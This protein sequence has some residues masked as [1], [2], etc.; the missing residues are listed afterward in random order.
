M[1][2]G[3]RWLIAFP[4]PSGYPHI[5]QPVPWRPLMSLLVLLSMLC[6][7]TADDLFQDIANALKRGRNE[8]ALAL[9]E[10]AIKA[11]PKNPQ[12]YL[13]RGLVHAALQKHTEAVADFDKA[14]ELDPKMA[15]AYDQRGSER[16]KQGKIADALADFDRFLELRPKEYSG[17]WRRGIALYYLGKYEEGRKQFGA[18]EKVDTNDVENAVWHFLCNARLVGVEKARGEMLKIGN[19]K[20]VPLMQGYALFKGEIKPADVLTA[21]NA[22]KPSAAELKARLFY[23]HLYLGLYYEALGDGK[24]AL[25]HMTRAAEDYL[26]PGYMGDVARVHA[27]LRKKEAK[28]K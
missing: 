26:L 11:D 3:V 25:E 2:S 19:D 15:E 23:A 17:H 6:L 1:L 22:G 12:A 24:R 21:A 13:A 18:Y 8:E 9:A 28:P 27:E 4:P 16:F 14:I 5:T 20:R 7:T 10:K